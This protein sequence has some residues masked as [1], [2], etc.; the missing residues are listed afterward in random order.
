MPGPETFAKAAR[1]QRQAI[2]ADKAA[3][4]LHDEQV[5]TVAPVNSA[6]WSLQPVRRA[7][8]RSTMA[9]GPPVRD[10][11]VQER[12]QQSWSFRAAPLAKRIASVAFL[13]AF[14]GRPVVAVDGRLLWPFGRLACAPHC[15]SFGAGEIAAGPWVALCQASA[16]LLA[17][18]VT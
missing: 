4:R 13:Y 10:L 7:A 15:G 2:E 9:A 11:G 16:S 17:K 14:W 5:S 12:V 3:K 1:L 8:C 6:P 18:A